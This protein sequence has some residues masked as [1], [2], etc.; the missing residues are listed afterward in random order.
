MKPTASDLRE[1]TQ[2]PPSIC[3]SL[4]DITNI[5]DAFSNSNTGIWILIPNLNRGMMFKTTDPHSFLAL[6]QE[7]R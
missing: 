3:P 5:M 2:N 1:L 4:S 6:I 7:P